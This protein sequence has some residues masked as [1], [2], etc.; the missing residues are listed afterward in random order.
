MKIKSRIRLNLGEL[1]PTG[2]NGVYSNSKRCFY[3]RLKV[4]G[5]KPNTLFALSIRNSYLFGDL[6]DSLDFSR[7]NYNFLNQKV[8]NYFITKAHSLSI[9]AN[10]TGLVHFAIDATDFSGPI[11]W[12]LNTARRRIVSILPN[13]YK[14]IMQQ[15]Y[16]YSEKRIQQ[17]IRNTY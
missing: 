7:S 5:I 9:I 4:P 3:Y 10:E 17:I 8:L 14:L 11:R 1:S 16:T 12:H 2:L 6:I 15:T 13:T